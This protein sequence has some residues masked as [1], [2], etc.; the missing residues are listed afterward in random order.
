MSP[1]AN[2]IKLLTD[3]SVIAMWNQQNLPA[4]AVSTENGTILSNSDRYPL[5]IDP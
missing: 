4:D 2:P 1:N 3:E 5:L